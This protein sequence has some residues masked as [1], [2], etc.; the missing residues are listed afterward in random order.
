[1]PV[2][3]PSVAPASVLPAVNALVPSTLFVDSRK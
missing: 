3:S 2:I 1:V